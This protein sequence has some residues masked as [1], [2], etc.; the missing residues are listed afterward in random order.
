MS[1]KEKYEQEILQV[2]KDNKIFS[3]SDIFAFYKGCCSSTFYYHELEK[4]EDIKR[5]I[6]DNKTITKQA[7]LARWFKSDNATL[8]IA[9]YKRICT[10]AERQMLNQQYIDHTTQGEK[11]TVNVQKYDN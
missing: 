3:I 10:D 1:K 6:E 4:S 7:L 2:I 5:A 9:L 8:Q 11:I